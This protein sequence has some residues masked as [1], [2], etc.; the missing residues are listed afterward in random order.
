MS[1]VITFSRVFPSYHPKKGEPTFFVEQI[2]NSIYGE[3]ADGFE[4]I[5]GMINASGITEKVFYEFSDSL[6]ANGGLKHHTIRAGTRWKVGDK[7]S[8]RVWSGKPYQSKQIPIAPDIEIKKIWHFRIEPNGYILDMEYVNLTQL[9]AIAK[10]D[11]LSVDELE[12][13]FAPYAKKESVNCQILCWN[14][15]VQY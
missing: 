12:L 11:G 7:F 9:S 8:P 1:R 4:K 6:K 5:G 10:N 13:W 15:S 2:W 3:T 14:Q